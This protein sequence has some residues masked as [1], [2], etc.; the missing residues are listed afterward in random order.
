MRVLPSA[1]LAMLLIGIQPSDLAILQLA[2]NN[3]GYH[4]TP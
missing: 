1:G 3:R 2:V 4:T